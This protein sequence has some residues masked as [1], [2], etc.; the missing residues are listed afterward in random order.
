[1]I[2]KGIIFFRFINNTLQLYLSKNNDDKYEDITII[3][4]LNIIPLYKFYDNFNM[5]YFLDI[6]KYEN[7]YNKIISEDIDKNK[8][9]CISLSTFNKP[10]IHKYAKIKK[11]K[12][13]EIEIILNK[14]KLNYT[15]R[16]KIKHHL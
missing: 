5:I 15:I 1:M 4:D 13:N 7:L 8:I 2:H 3:E 9:F 6:N 12:N 14:I 16:T 11:L 10:S